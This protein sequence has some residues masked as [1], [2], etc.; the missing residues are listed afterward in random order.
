MGLATLTH[1]PNPM[2]FLGE[3]LRA[4]ENWRP[5]ILFPVG[6][7]AADA[8]VPDLKRKDLDEI[9]RWM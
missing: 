9:L 3:I 5:F 4:P 7:P 8:T 2:G 6:Y 1:T